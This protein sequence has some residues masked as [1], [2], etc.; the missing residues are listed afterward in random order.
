MYVQDDHHIGFLH[1]HH[2]QTRCYFRSKETNGHDTP[3]TTEFQASNDRNASAMQEIVLV[4]TSLILTTIK[5]TERQMPANFYGING[6]YRM[7]PRSKTGKI[8]RSLIERWKGNE[9]MQSSSSRHNIPFELL[10][11]SSI[12]MT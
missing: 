10:W 3:T 9:Q 4:K 2:V 12:M 11:L 8:N 5:H 1:G 6:R 7:R